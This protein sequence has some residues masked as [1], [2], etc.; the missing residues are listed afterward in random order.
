[1]DHTH[2]EHT[3]SQQISQNKLMKTENKPNRNITRDPSLQSA[4]TVCT[5]SC[6]SWSAN[7]HIKSDYLSTYPY[8]SWDQTHEVFANRS[9][10]SSTYIKSGVGLPDHRL[11][12]A[13]RPKMTNVPEPVTEQ[14]ID[15]AL[16]VATRPDVGPLRSPDGCFRE[17]VNG[18]LLP[19]NRESDEIHGFFLENRIC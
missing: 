2:I 3:Y 11:L 17:V 12:Q 15:N 19:T 10:A 8:N 9:T 13:P 1:M 14:Q 4:P 16:K 18:R 5:L 6:S 7:T